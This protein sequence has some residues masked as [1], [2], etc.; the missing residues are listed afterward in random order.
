MSQQN[1]PQAKPDRRNYTQVG[2]EILGRRARLLQNVR[3]SRKDEED[4]ENQ[5]KRQ[6]GK[7]IYFGERKFKIQRKYHRGHQAGIK[8]ADGQ[9]DQ[10]FNGC[11]FPY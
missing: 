7:D 8:E 1:K 9:I 4:D 3:F 10:E 5:I 2:S 6:V 11:S